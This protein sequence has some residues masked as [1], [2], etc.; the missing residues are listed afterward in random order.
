MTEN[1]EIHDAIISAL[2]HGVGI[3]N[4]VGHGGIDVWGD[5]TVLRNE[6]ARMLKNGRRLPIFT[7]FTCLNGYFNHPQV[8]ALA[9]TLLWT[10]DGGIVAAVAPSGRTFTSQQTPLATTFYSS[11]LN[12][13]AGTLGEA[14][15]QAKVAAA[16]NPDLTE[17]IHTFNLLGDPALRFMT[18]AEAQARHE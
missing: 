10:A 14:L 2:N 8:D 5:E 9:E 17:V 15:M 4:Y 12:G 7:T 13:D 18:P 3:V 16:G 6:D 1:E 11:L